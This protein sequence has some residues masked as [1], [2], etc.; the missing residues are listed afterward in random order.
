MLIP[1]RRLFGSPLGALLASPAAAAQ[2]ASP[3]EVIQAAR[4]TALAVLKPT[5]AQVEHGLKLHAATLVVESYGFSP[6][7]AVDGDSIR[8]AVEAGASQ[9]ELQDLLEGQ[10]M[11][12]QVTSAAERAEYLDAWRA[13]GV[14]AIIQNAGEEGSHP[15]RLIKR[16]ARFTYSTHHL[17]DHVPLAAQPDEVEAARRAGRHALVF[18]T[19]GVPVTS[20]WV[21]VEDELRYLPVFFQ[22]GV[23]MM[24]LTYNRRNLIGE[25]CGEPGNAGLSDFGRATIREMNRLGVIVDTA[26][27]GWRTSLE[28][29]RAS[30]KPIMASH[31][32]CGALNPHVRSKPD[33][34]IRSIVDGGGLIG[35]CC[36]PEFLGRT[37][38]I[39]AMLDHIE[40]AVKTF[41]P[42]HVAIGTD[43][44]YQSRNAAAEVRKIPRRARER[45]RWEALWP[46][47]ALGGATPQQVRSMAWTNWPV[48]TIGMVQRGFKDDD[49]RKILGGNVMRVLRANF[50]GVRV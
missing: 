39:A 37:R 13:S 28:A 30:S 2:L 38:D 50:D 3:N 15:M 46:A 48:F 10:A 4:E 41:G 8:L 6:R 5:T 19:N 14:T 18:T 12:R 16:L 29:A 21:S 1:R 22:L 34:V 17:R 43:V 31:T 11:T 20:E 27:S 47:G 32:V 45:V 23:R 36:I 9:I 25:G 7:A 35:I 40:Y 26:H 33:E 49:I 42:D 44:A 24:H